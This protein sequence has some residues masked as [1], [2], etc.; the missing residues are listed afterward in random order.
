MSGSQL[1]VGPFNRVE[2]DLEIRLELEDNKVR[3]AYANSP[4]FRGFERMLLGKGPMDALTITPR[5]CGICS[6]S[7]SA[8]A[9]RALADA[10]GL[11]PAPEG[12]RV[13]A[14]LHA[15][16]N[17]ADHI[18]HFNLFFMPDFARR[19]Y[20][21][22]PWHN[23]AVARFTAMKGSALHAV[24]EA[25]AG[26]LHIVGLLGGKWPHTLAIQP[27]GVTRAPTLRDKIRIGASLRAFRTHLENEL[28][29]ARVEA[30]AELESVDQLDAWASGDAGLFFEVSRALG[31]EN[32]GRG[33]ARYLSYGA[34]PGPD[35]VRFARGTWSEGVLDALDTDLIEEDLSH[36]W[37]LGEDAH[38][39]S[40]QTL[41]D[42]DMSDAGYSWC[43]APR[44]GNA[45]Y[46]TGALAR[47]VI[48]GHPLALALAGEDSVRARIV[49]RLLEIARTQIALEEMLDAINPK[50]GFMTPLDVPREGQGA[51]LVEAARG[52][53][54]HWIRIEDGR[55]AS[56][57][58]IAPTT[59]NFS[60][61]DRRG[62]PGP[63]EAAL[64][65]A[66]V[67]EGEDTPLSV[68]HIVRSYD[69]CMVCTV[70]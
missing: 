1:I 65:G 56:Y 62:V 48:D 41:P 34:Y 43:K 51:G 5:I 19:D 37:M 36:A 3:S 68:Q 7:Q 21:G 23:T 25:R 70:H 24:T 47:Q 32:I 31:L 45:S 38:P 60:P 61:R 9:A 2:G 12:E 10:A 11:T 44:L 50:A 27:G 64:E 15:V 4:L 35:G 26:L 49:G 14:L 33:G 16:E 13:A 28:F 42:E 63:V 20:A 30:F 54:G 67:G 57:Q 6:I 46:E 18:T 69:P 22:N 55:I 39:T 53:L 52:S 8:A 40:G 17:M 59:W 58:I 66:P 29:G